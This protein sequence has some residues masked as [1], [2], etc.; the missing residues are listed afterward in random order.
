MAQTP[1]MPP[2]YLE[3]VRALPRP[4][5]EQIEAFVQHV[6]GAENW[7]KLLPVELGP[8]LVVFLDPNAGTRVNQERQGGRYA[9]EPLTP[10]SD[11]VHGSE[12]PTDSHRERFGFLSYHIDLGGGTPTL[13]AGVLRRALLPE[14]GV[15]QRG[16]LVPLPDPIRALATRPGAFLHGTF[17]SVPE[18]GRMRRFRYAVEKLAKV[19]RPPGDHPLIGRIDAWVRKCREEDEAGFRAW[20]REGHDQIPEDLEDGTRWQ[21]YVEWRDEEVCVQMHQAQ[22]EAFARTGIPDAVAA[23]HGRALRLLR[24]STHSMLDLLEELRVG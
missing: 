20:L 11:L 3:L 14:P 23:E 17:R 2:A 4:Q 21:R 7:L 9:V 15:V 1:G 22:D 13:E 19:D 5:E 16:L 12:L 18:R 24:D 8:E 10:A 6:A